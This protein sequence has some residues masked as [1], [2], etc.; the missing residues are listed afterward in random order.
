[1]AGDD[2]FVVATLGTNTP[3][4]TAGV[5]T[6]AVFS[7][8]SADVTT[9]AAA[10][11]A[12]LLEL[13][14]VTFPSI[15]YLSGAANNSTAISTA[16]QNFATIP[17]GSVSYSVAD[18][19]GNT[20]PTGDLAGVTGSIT[21]A[22][23]YF[24]PTAITCVTTQIA[25]SGSATI[26]DDYFQSGTYGWT[27]EISVTLSGTYTPTASTFS[28]IHS[29]TNRIVT[30]TFANAAG[31]VTFVTPVN[32]PT[33]VTAGSYALVAVA[34]S[35]LQQGV[36]V[37]L[38]LCTTCA[39][40]TSSYT[41]GFGTTDAP[42][43]AG[44]T[45]SSGEFGG[46]FYV[47]TTAGTSAQVN[48]TWTQT[49]NGPT[50]TSFTTAVPSNP[51]VTVAGTPAEFVIV[52]GFGSQVYPSTTDVVNGTTV[53]VDISLADAYGN[54]TVAPTGPQIQISLSASAGLFSAT[55]VYI[56]GTDASTNSTG[57][58]ASF[59][60]ID[61]TAPVS[62]GTTVTLTASGVINGKAVH[63]TSTITTVS[64]LPTMSVTSPAPLSGVIYSNNPTVVFTGEANVSIGYPTITFAPGS[65]TAVTIASVGIKVGS[66]TWTSATIVTPG[67]DVTWNAV[68][69][70]TIGLNT[71]EF[72]ATDINGNVVFSSTYKVLVE[73]AAPTINFVTPSGA[74]L[75]YSTPLQANIIDPEGDLNASSVSA[76]YNGTA[77]PSTDLSLSGTNKLG[78]SVTY[79]LSISNLPVGNW[80]IV[81]TASNFAQNT[82]T[83]TTSVSVLVSFAQSVVITSATQGTLGSFKGISVS[84]TNLWSTSQNL[85]VF[86]VFKNSVGQTVAVATGGLTL[87]AGA[88]G[89][90]F[91][92]SSDLATL[93]GTYS[94]SVFVITT[95]NEPVSAATS[96]TATF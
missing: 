38:Q 18:A 17:G 34:F 26:A 32:D 89:T 13:N 78:T 56:P 87:G 14:A 53:S 90:A 68:A 77:L 15:Q 41:G 80:T 59:G 37:I 74:S 88:S 65:V 27:G 10:P 35:P 7:G 58:P 29:P 79:P 21:A 28:G 30:S 66:G 93:S 83:N 49:T 84:A 57:P 36:P 40:T 12:V 39:S 95:S 72:N 55:T 45:N 75:N 22:A 20:V 42:A 54:P 82:G 62:I 5:S 63:G 33:D 3:T 4:T 85:V 61:Y 16:S 71:V 48:A 46:A 76:T 24:C 6:E 19:Y 47:D 60:S 2:N 67:S 11:S 8:S 73:T 81:V 86:A 25:T 44:I 91:A 52:T 23:G 94:V 96:I 92:T 50:V 31:D 1:V 51:M 69:F 70:L 9:Q 64:A 43:L